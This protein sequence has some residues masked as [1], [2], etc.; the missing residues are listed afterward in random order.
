MSGTKPRLLVIRLGAL[1]DIVLSL[2]P[3]AAIRRHHPGAEITLLTTAPYA[4]FLAKSPYADRVWI[5]ERAPW[6]RLDRQ[7]AFR[8]RLNKAGFERVYDLQTSG[9]SARYLCLFKSPK[10]EWSG[11]APGASHSDQVNPLRETSHTIDRQREQLRLAGIDVV[12]PSDLSWVKATDVARFELPE[13]FALLVPGGSAHRPEKRWPEAHYIALGRWLIGQGITP[14][15][16]G[17]EA[18]ANLAARITEAL[19]GAVNLAARTSLEDLVTLAGKAAFAI[20]NDTGPIHLL[21]AA[22]APG[23]VLFS[24]ASDPARCAPRQLRVAILQSPDLADLTLDQVTTA[25]GVL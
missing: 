20:G 13:R 23:A 7:F 25:L 14:A 8:R 2:G 1:G 22:G 5:D 18:E 17:A 6:W 4:A 21:A 9:R 10:P 3:M 11:H 16:V 12:A 15:I 19:P 24:D